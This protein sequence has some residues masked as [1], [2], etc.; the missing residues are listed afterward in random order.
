MIPYGKYR[1]IVTNV[2]DEKKMG[3]IRVKCPKIYGESESPYCLPCIPNGYFSLPEI[4]ST[5]WIEFEELDTEKPIYSGSWWT[6]ENTPLGTDYTEAKDM[7]ILKTS[8]GHTLTFY[9]KSGEEY[10]EVEDKNNN[11]ITINNTGVIIESVGDVSFNVTQGNVT[12]NGTRVA[13]ITD[14]P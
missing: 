4:G 10:I 1:A 13:L 11:K 7:N 9:D 8:S 5:V 2:S 6:R 3:R 14:I 12:V